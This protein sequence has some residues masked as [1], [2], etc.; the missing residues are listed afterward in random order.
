MTG[1][2]PAPL[3]L[4]VTVLQ[5]AAALENLAV[6]VYRAAAGL[7]FAPPGSRLRELTDRNQA[8]H[9]AHAQAFNQALAKAGAAQQHA[10]D[11][12]YGSVPQ[13]AAA[14]PDPVSLIGLLTEVEGILGQSCARYAALAADGAVR[15]LFVSV[16]SVEAQHG[17]ELLLARLLPT[18]GAT[19]LALPE[20]TGTAG[21]PHTAYPT[22][23]ASA[24]GEG[25]VR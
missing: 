12:R 1:S 11:P 10:V 17:S 22:A 25:A 4:D 7:P 18:D 6:A 19:A 24:I 9:A 13:R 14:T 15:S 2:P 23:Q 3:P 16:A 21:I 5:T 20:S 8:H